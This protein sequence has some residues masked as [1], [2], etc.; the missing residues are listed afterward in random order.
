MSAPSAS[1]GFSGVTTTG[2]YC[3]PGCPARP[4]PD[5]VRPF[6]SA[7]AAEAAGFRA[8]LRC[9]PYRSDPVAA[10]VGAA[11]PALVCRAV[12][13]VLD[14]ALDEGTEARLGARLG[15][16]A[17]H[18]RRLFLAHVGVTPDQL[19]RSRRAHFARRLLDD[20]DLPMTDV[21]FAAG[22]GSVR[23]LHRSLREVFRAAPTELRARRRAHDR[24]VADG[25]LPVRLG[26]RG[27][28]D[29]ASMLRYLADRAV[30]GVEHVADGWYRRTVEIDG[31]PGVLEIGGRSGVGDGD[32]HLVL[33]A[34]L[35]HW[36]GLIHV[37]QRARRI[38]ALDADHATAL[39]HLSA[40]PALGPLVRCASGLRVPG[41]WDP[42]EVGV[43]AVLGQQVSVRGANTLA[44]R[45]VAR[46]G[47]PVPGLAPFGLTHVFPTPA[48]LGAADPADLARL[49]LPRARAAAIRAFAAAV[50][51]DEIRLDRSVALDDL[52][53][54]V[55]A[56]PGLGAW[57]AHYV[58]LRMGEPDA[59]PASD[60]G[61]RRAVAALVGPHGP[62]EERAA[63]IVARWR[64][65]RGLAA[66]HLWA[67][68]INA[69]SAI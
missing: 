49:G 17:R 67:A 55:T 6:G 11:G 52:V 1:T 18:L 61:L 27:P 35:P 58:A 34:H 63:A 16:S 21:A 36:E 13:M 62:D 46:F 31:D 3:R 45:L 48:A 33:R 59:F 64:P 15:V 8:C 29:E 30:P 2:I 42:F 19:A 50:A 66:V 14:G 37:V 5:H 26:V 32:D 51:A 60:L 69:L 23:Q 44:G 43:R 10:A 39:E 20:T 4:R 53:A 57:T 7:A 28:L 12:Q 56:V 9:R 40:D 41:T 22:Y 25:G 24:L 47:R 68:D 65:W 54:S 38:F